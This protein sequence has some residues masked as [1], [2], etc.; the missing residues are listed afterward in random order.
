M[1][2]EADCRCGKHFVL[3]G[4]RDECRFPEHRQPPT[5]PINAGQRGRP[6]WRDNGEP[7]PHSGELVP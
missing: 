4:G 3:T 5:M 7:C 1:T 2:V 6:V